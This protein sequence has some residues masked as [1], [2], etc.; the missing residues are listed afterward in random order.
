MTETIPYKEADWIIKQYV[1]QLN[2]ELNAFKTVIIKW[3]GNISISSCN[4]I[5]FTPDINLCCN[6]INFGF[7]NFYLPQLKELESPKEITGKEEKDP[8]IVTISFNKRILIRTVSVAA[9]VLA[10]FLTPAPL[11]NNS[12][13]YVSNASFFPISRI[14]G[15]EKEELVSEDLRLTS[16]NEE[17]STIKQNDNQTNTR[18]YYII[19]AS[20]PTKDQAEKAL[21]DFKQTGFPE[22]ALLS[23]EGRHRIYIKSFEERTEAESYLAIFRQ[24]NPK[25]SDAWLFSQK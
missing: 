17:V 6:G 25:Y 10:L 16:V 21:A 23:K 12:G 9:A 18:R 11:N 8:V 1:N 4:K 15:N 2:E 20:L 3:V 19:I 24:N 22:V 14:A 13:Q 7:N 5:I